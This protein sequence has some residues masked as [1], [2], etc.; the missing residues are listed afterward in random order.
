MENR[1]NYILV[2]TFT[3]AIIASIF[4]F[5]WWFRASNTS[6]ERV[7]YRVVFTG[8]VSG[9]VRGA[10]VRF[11]GLRVGEVKT[12]ELMP[13]DPSRVQATIE[14]DP[15]TPIRADT[16]ASLQYQGL[17]GVAAVQLVGG[18]NKAPLISGAETNN[19][20][21]LYADRSDFQ[22]VLETAQRLSG[23]ID[24]IVSR[25]DKLVGDN[26]QQVGNIIRNAETVS[27]SL[28]DHVSDFDLNGL[29]RSIDNIVKISDILGSHSNDVDLALKDIAS[30]TTKL[31]QSADKIDNVL[32]AAQSFLGVEGGANG[33]TKNM[34]SEITETAKSFRVLAQNLDK[35]ASEITS[36]VSKFSGSG[37]RDFEALSNDA[38]KAFSDISRAV[39]NFD[40]N[41]N[42]I[43]FGGKQPVPDY[44][45][46]K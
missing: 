24:N 31:N 29:N 16:R 39:R 13:D 8:S 33:L 15:K 7:S 6:S 10:T 22:D 41:P 35:R 12:I 17:T 28:A 18:S 36:S 27:K 4:T 23:K 25:F 20:L 45:G 30:I 40:R 46:G 38:R 19:V 21:T 1:A 26:E 11:N 3:L 32:S 34:F 5:I 43:I 42:Q 2:G 37:L 9:L 44:N 14:V